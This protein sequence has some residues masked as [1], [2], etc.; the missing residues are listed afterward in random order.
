MLY[1][2]KDMYE[3][4]TRVNRLNDDSGEEFFADVVEQ[5]KA[6]LT[7]LQDMKEEKE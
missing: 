7:A 5:T 4:P 2:T 3:I 6:I 1:A